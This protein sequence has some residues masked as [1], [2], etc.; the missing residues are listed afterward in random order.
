V[1]SEPVRQGTHPKGSARA[2]QKKNGAPAEI[3]RLVVATPE[4]GLKHAAGE[5]KIDERSGSGYWNFI[6]NLNLIQ[7]SNE[8]KNSAGEPPWTLPLPV[9]S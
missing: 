8:T 1:Q 3:N 5:K 7:I 9:S 6:L 2:C 4:T